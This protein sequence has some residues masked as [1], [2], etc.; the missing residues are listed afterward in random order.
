MNTQGDVDDLAAQESKLVLREANRAMRELTPGLCEKYAGLLSDDARR[1]FYESYR[2]NLQTGSCCKFVLKLRSPAR[3][4]CSD[5]ATTPTDVA[6]FVGD[7]S[8]S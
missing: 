6:E 8:A 2:D 5:A 3:I 1:K 7:D 4:Q